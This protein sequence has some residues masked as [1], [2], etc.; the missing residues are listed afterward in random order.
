MKRYAGVL[1]PV[2]SLPS[3]YGIGCFDQ[4]AYDFVDWLQKAGQRYWQI[5]PLGA[6][7]YGSSD[8]SPYQAYSAFAG[9]PYLISLDALVEE[10]VLTREECDGVSFGDNPA[11]VD[12]DKL[13]EHR[14]ALLRKA[15]E[16][17][18]QVG[19]SSQSKM[20]Q[21]D[22]ELYGTYIPFSMAVCHTI[23]HKSGMDHTTYAH[24]GAMVNVYAMGVGAEK[25]GG[26]YDNTEIYHKLAELTKVQ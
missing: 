21:Q 1:L 26:V 2:T 10:G 8:D 20:S 16:R 7:S 15:Y 14:F 5:L 11:K 24:T 3:K 18:L 25:F 13:H 12:F 22:Y 9:N 6:T 19:S 17:T 4:A 23:N